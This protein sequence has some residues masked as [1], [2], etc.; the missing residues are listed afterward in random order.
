MTNSCLF[1][2]IIDIM[3]ICIAPQKAAFIKIETKI[4]E[5]KCGV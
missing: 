1:L 5:G 3:V 4:S 2:P